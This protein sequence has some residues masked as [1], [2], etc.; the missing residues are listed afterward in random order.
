MN[1]YDIGCHISMYDCDDVATTIILNK[2]GAKNSIFHWSDLTFYKA[3]NHAFIAHNLYFVWGDVHYD[4]HSSN[5]FVDKK[6]NIGCIYKGAFDKITT[7]RTQRN[8]CL[9]NVREGY[10]NVAFFDTS[11]SDF[12]G[13]TEKF[14]IRYIT[15]IRDFCRENKDIN[16]LLKPKNSTNM[17]LNALKTNIGKYKEMMIFLID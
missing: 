3:Y 8:G 1:A 13:Y 14:F 7:G 15:M 16:V 11:F 2:Y 4:Y 6:I 17:V 10:K 9:K 12:C 5:Y